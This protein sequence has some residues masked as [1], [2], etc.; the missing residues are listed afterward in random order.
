MALPRSLSS[1]Q[2]LSES[3]R[4]A[5]VAWLKTTGWVSWDSRCVLALPVNA[6]PSRGKVHAA[7]ISRQPTI[8]ENL[9]AA[10]FLCAPSDKTGWKGLQDNKF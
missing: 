7:R 9:S 5:K 4:I 8:L 2:L 6:L 3:V 1:K 10:C